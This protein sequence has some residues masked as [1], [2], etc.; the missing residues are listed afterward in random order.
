LPNVL[1]KRRTKSKLLPPPN[2]LEKKRKNLR[3]SNYDVKKRPR[4]ELQGKLEQQQRFSQRSKDW[5]Q[6]GMLKMGHVNRPRYHL[7]HV[8]Q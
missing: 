6:R 8:D 4:L 1:K 7:S 2:A 3:K 5:Q